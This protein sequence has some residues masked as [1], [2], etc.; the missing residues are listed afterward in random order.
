M[1]CV[2][3]QI[4]NVFCGFLASVVMVATNLLNT[5][6]QYSGCCKAAVTLLR[7]TPV[8]SQSWPVVEPLVFFSRSWRY[9]WNGLPEMS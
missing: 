7:V 5:A 6:S 4:C 8:M 3:T 2:H 1:A 9:Y